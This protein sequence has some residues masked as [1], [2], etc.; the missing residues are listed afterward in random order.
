[1]PHQ[2]ILYSG[3]T[4]SGKER[5]FH[6]E[7]GINS[8]RDIKTSR[9]YKDTG[10]RGIL[11]LNRNVLTLKATGTKFESPR[12]SGALYNNCKIEDSEARPIGSM[13]LCYICF[14]APTTS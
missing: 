1:M 8:L 4:V 11:S 9:V 13:L 5:S 3:R 6:D 12:A 2:K 10:V 14:G 7:K